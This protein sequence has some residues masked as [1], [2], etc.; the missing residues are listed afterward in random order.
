MSYYVWS[1]TDN[2]LG[3]FRKSPGKNF[4]FMPDILTLFGNVFLSIKNTK[5]RDSDH[6]TIS[7][8]IH[9]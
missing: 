7:T 8:S 6:L 1:Y 2:F 5:Q 4:G 3:I 9:F